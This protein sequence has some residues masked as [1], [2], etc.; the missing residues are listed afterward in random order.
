MSEEDMLLFY[1]LYNFN[2]DIAP[3]LCR[4]SQPYDIIGVSAEMFFKITTAELRSA[5]GQPGGGKRPL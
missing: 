4:N 5:A 2:R 3:E 1:T